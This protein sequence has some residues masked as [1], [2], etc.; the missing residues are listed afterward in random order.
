MGKIQPLKHHYRQGGWRTGGEEALWTPQEAVRS[1]DS[2][3]RKAREKQKKTVLSK[4][5]E[6]RRESWFINEQ[7][8]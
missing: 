1:M 7:I 3:V 8:I 4:L 2:A 6:K 5:W